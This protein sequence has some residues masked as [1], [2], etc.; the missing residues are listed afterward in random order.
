MYK[1]DENATLENIKNRLINVVESTN[2]CLNLAEL[3]EITINLKKLVDD[4]AL[5]IEFINLE[6]PVILCRLL[7]L[8]DM[9]EKVAKII[10]IKSKLLYLEGLEG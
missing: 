5:V 8:N 4:Y 9:F 2:K 6:D 3:L 10:S 7:I 1:I